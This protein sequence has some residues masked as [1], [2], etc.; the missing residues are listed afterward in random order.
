[1][2]KKHSYRLLIYM[3]ILLMLSDT[4][5]KLCKEVI[6]P[7]S[8][9]N[10]IKTYTKRQVYASRNPIAQSEFFATHTAGIKPE[11]V[12]TVS[13][14]D[15]DGEEVIEWEGVLYSVYRTYENRNELTEL[16]VEKKL[17]AN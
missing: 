17:G 14:L 1:M 4:V 5:I 7:D 13:A 10:Q 3:E 8:I 6:E 9:G 12:F 2:N 11:H 15:Y 16:Y